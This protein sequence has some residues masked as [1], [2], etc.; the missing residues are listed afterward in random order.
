MNQPGEYGEDEFAE[1][2]T[3]EFFSMFEDQTWMI[4]LD[5]TGEEDDSK[6]KKWRDIKPTNNN[7]VVAIA[8]TQEESWKQAVMEIAEVVAMMKDRTVNDWPALEDCVSLICSEDGAIYWLFKL[9]LHWE[10]P[11]FCKF[12]AT[13]VFQNSMNLSSTTLYCKYASRAFKYR[14][15]SKEEFNKAWDTIG[16]LDLPGKG[17]PTNSLGDDKKYF[18]KNDG[19]DKSTVSSKS[20]DDDYLQKFVIDDFKVY[21][22]SLNKETAGLKI[23]QQHTWANQRGPVMHQVVK[24]ASGVIIGYYFEMGGDSKQTATTNMLKG[25]LTAMVG[26]DGSHM[27]GLE[28]FEGEGDRAYNKNLKA[29]ARM[30]TEITTEEYLLPVE[31]RM[32]PAKT[33]QDRVDKGVKDCWLRAPFQMRK[34]Y[35]GKISLLSKYN[36]IPA[37]FKQASESSKAP[38]ITQL[39]NC[40]SSY[41]RG[42]GEDF[43]NEDDIPS[44][45][46]CSS[47]TKVDAARQMQSK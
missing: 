27:S 42:N 41:Y 7:V 38:S 12:L 45:S 4:D 25:Q 33:L 9:E 44:S 26:G 5:G 32:N 6:V 24:T 19:S 22:V 47:A 15:L 31:L 36:S 3:W 23:S 16:K 10:Y 30:L 11:L 13:I 20:A 28:G 8:E 43:H 21:F 46:L 2:E 14:L 37:Q 17:E 40:L 1:D 35:F 39:R 18:W 29:G 34:A